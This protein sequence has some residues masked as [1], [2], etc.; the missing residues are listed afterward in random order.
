M[1]R[2]LIADDHP[3]VRRGLKEILERE[4]EGTVCAEAKDA[5]D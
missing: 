2:V 5:Q 1:I 3:V 4:L